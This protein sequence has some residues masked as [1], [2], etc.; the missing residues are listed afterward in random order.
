MGRTRVIKLI[1][2]RDGCSARE[3]EGL[4]EQAVREMESCG[5]NSDECEDIM[6]NILGL[7]MDYIFDILY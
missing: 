6:M 5:Y 3:A 7:E 1:R 4:I 2:N